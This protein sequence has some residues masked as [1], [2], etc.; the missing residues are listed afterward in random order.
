[1]SKI[2]KIGIANRGVLHHNT[3]SP[4]S[5]EEWF[6]EVAQSKVFDYVDKTPPKE[7]FNKY[8][9]LSE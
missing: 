9:S 4:I 8:Q 2:L 5:L 1:M 3:E 6:K 7:D